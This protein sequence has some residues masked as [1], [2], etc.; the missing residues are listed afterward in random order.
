MIGPPAAEYRTAA[1]NVGRLSGVPRAVWTGSLAFGLV[2]IPVRLYP[3]TEPK[4]VRFHLTDERGRRVR[5]RR[6]VE[7]AEDREAMWA[8]GFADAGPAAAPGRTDEREADVGDGPDAEREADEAEIRDR[9][10]PARMSSG[11][12]EIAFEDLRRGYET[13]DGRLVVLDR[14]DIEAVRPE[15]SRRIEIED[16]VSLADIDPVY[17][18]K[19]YNLA[20]QRGAEK[21]YA[22]LLRAIE[23]AGRVGIGR[24]VLRT[25]PHL[26]AIRASSGVLGLETMFFADEVRS[27]RDVVPGIDGIEVSERELKLAEALIS[28]L[29]TTWDPAAYSDTYRQDL[30][31]RIAE[32]APVEAPDEAAVDVTGSG[33]RVEALMEALKASVEAAKAAKKTAPKNAGPKKTEPNRSRKTS[34]R[35]RARSA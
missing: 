19:S 28:T 14:E 20:P 18:E 23:R 2:N 12:E 6:F 22:L 26:V 34:S 32:K 1:G 4:D 15:R 8:S 16:F 17:F 7:A 35:G 10:T 27:G 13:D 3:A 33:A 24:F 30:L 9:G 5:Y 11:G 25:K 21:P 29:E 31:R